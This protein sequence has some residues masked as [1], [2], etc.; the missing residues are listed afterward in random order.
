LISNVLLDGLFD[1][2]SLA[3]FSSEHFIVS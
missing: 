2:V 3:L 1:Q